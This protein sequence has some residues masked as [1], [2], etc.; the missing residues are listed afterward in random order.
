MGDLRSK[1]LAH[2]GAV[3]VAAALVLPFSSAA[4]SVNAP[5]SSAQASGQLSGPLA[6][7]SSGSRA[8]QT[9]PLAGTG[10]AAKID[11][12]AARAAN[13]RRPVVEGTVR[14]RVQQVSAMTS[15]DVP[16][17]ALS[18]YR[19]A[20]DILAAREPGCHLSWTML[21]AI[22]TV[23]SD[24]G[25]F[26]G[27]VV[28]ADGETSPRI[29]GPV[30]D[31]KGGVGAIRDTDN[32]RLDGD[33][34]WDRAVGPM[35]FIPGTWALYGADGNGDGV[36]DPDNMY[37]AALAAADYLCAGG[38][39]LSLPI[40]ARAAILRYNH[41][42]AYATLVMR[43][44]HAYATGAAIVV[45]DGSSNTGSHP[46]RRTTGKR[47]G[48]RPPA[49]RGGGSTGGTDGSGGNGTGGGSGGNGTGG[50]SGGNGTGG[51][52]GGGSGGKGGN[53]G[54][55][56]HHP[57]SP[58]HK[59][60]TLIGHNPAAPP[61]GPIQSTPSHSATDKAPATKAQKSAQPAPQV[62]VTGTL[63]VTRHRDWSVGD[64]AL[65]FG[66]GADLGLRQADYDADGHLR[67]VQRELESLEGLTVQV[68]QSPNQARTDA[69]SPSSPPVPPAIGTPAKGKQD[70]SADVTIW[71]GAD[72]VITSINGLPYQVTPSAS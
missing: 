61:Q 51:G 28:L 42:A 50:G 53:G 6:T 27:A 10:E 65:D 52:S 20:A 13:G 24:N 72:G 17:A 41:S 67:S 4:A 37:D 49:H 26:G 64:L 45:G 19:H 12:L 3:I 71:L 7:A 2:R 59:V 43:L 36:R 54:G 47:P 16:A 11:P 46:G 25:Q 57:T 35:Q 69:K 62:V 18:A 44:M 66:D 31:G 63:T 23:E 5:P 56:P 68:L 34:V 48:S 40:Q 15:Y 21:A 39:D 33:P 9:A 32:G 29:L 22:G 55:G 8:L 1:F 14:Q 38:G 30:L 60:A 58:V 70:D